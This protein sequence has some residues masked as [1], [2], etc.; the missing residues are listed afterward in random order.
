MARAIVTKLVPD[1]IG[2]CE[3]TASMT[4]MAQ[5]LTTASGSRFQVQPGHTGWKGYGTDIFYNSDKW[6]A[7]EGGVQTAGCSSRGGNRAANWAV[8]KDKATGEK[9]I[10]GG[11]HLSYCEGGC[12]SLHECELQALYAKLEEMKKKHP[13]APVVWMGDMNRNMQNTVMQNLLNGR[14]GSM[15]TF[16]ADDMGKTTKNTHMAGGGA[17]DHIIG[18]LGAFKIREGGS[19]GQGLTGQHL[20]GSDH[21]PIYSILDFGRR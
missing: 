11:I 5:A 15:T 3:L 17:I 14:I 21:F 18:E 1:I 12:D 16:K 20:E 4:E 13:S 19:T 10:T 8:L 7:F 6:E 2:L 9:L